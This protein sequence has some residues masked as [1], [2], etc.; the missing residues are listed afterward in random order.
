MAQRSVHGLYGRCSTRDGVWWPAIT[1]AA[2]AAAL[3]APAAA[4]AHQPHPSLSKSRPGPGRHILQKTFLPQVP[5]LY[6][7][8]CIC[9]TYLYHQKMLRNSSM[10]AALSCYARRLIGKTCI[11]FLC[12]PKRRHGLA[13][14]SRAAAPPP[15][16]LYD[17]WKIVILIPPSPFPP[18]LLCNYVFGLLFFILLIRWPLRLSSAPSRTSTGG[19]SSKRRALYKSTIVIL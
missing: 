3:T 17:I 11:F 5:V 14:P 1:G 6:I 8:I 10:H 19:S 9:S 15:S 4:L 12:L 7:H 2:G 16:S 13:R 18:F